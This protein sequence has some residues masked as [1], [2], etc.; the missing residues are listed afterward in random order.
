MRLFLLAMVPLWLVACAI[1]HDTSQRQMPTPVSGAS[2]NPS[3]PVTLFTDPPGGTIRID[4]RLFEHGQV[5][6]LPPGS[7]RATATRSGFREGAS[8]F[9]VVAGQSQTVVVQLGAAY[10]TVT[11]D[12]E[13]KDATVK[14]SGLTVDPSEERELAAREHRFEVSAPGFKAVADTFRVTPGS[15][16]TLAIDL[17]PLPT[18]GY[19]RI[20]AHHP[21]ALLR[22]NDRDIGT[23]FAE[24]DA[25]EYGQ[26]RLES[27]RKI[28]RWRREYASADF[29][30]D[31]SG[32]SLFETDNAQVQW[33]F[34]NTWLP[35]DDAL[36]AEQENYQNSRVANP[37][38]LQVG[39][40][41]QWLEKLESLNDPAAWLH[42]HMRIGDRVDVIIGNQ[43]WRIWK[44]SELVSPAFIETVSAL[45]AG[46]SYPLPWKADTDRPRPS[47]RVSITGLPELVYA[48]AEVDA[49]IPL[50]DLEQTLLQ[51]APES[52]LLLNVSAS[53]TPVEL[54]AH[55]GASLELDANA[56]IADEAGVRRLR[57]ENPG[58]YRISWQEAPQHLSAVPASSAARSQNEINTLQAN[59]KDLIEL[60]ISAEADALTQITVSPD[61]EIGIRWEQIENTAGFGRSIDLR[62]VEI[63]PHAFPGDYQRF[64]IAEYTSNGATA[65]RQFEQ[66]Y[67]VIDE[68]LRTETNEFLR[69]NPESESEN[70]G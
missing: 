56:L 35:A 1:P 34:E 67:S 68:R 49:R 33:W 39:A 2:I 62:K 11:F 46:T 37:T 21:E 28:D 30:F 20:N 29:S 53:D 25:L 38:H 59:E 58:R 5:T 50:I 61:P 10:G 41:S 16:Q 13:P 18:S 44:R 4:D 32:P 27:I 55:G 69:R 42:G 51:A 3:F 12:I 17:E 8:R 65:Q 31:I 70:D 36:V 47:D 7:Y 54:I 26:H 9:T 40:D 43:R 52:T 15:R 57:I 23:G 48:L 6:G 14:I 45:L 64:W 60:Q 22:L 24:I 19:V 66:R 63:G